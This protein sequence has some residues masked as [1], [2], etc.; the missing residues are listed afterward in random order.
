M[1]P[2]LVDTEAAD[3]EAGSGV[4][5][6]RVGVG[7]RAVSSTVRGVGVGAWM[8]GP[9]ADTLGTRGLEGVRLAVERLAVD[10][11]GPGEPAGLLTL[12]G[13]AAA[14]WALVAS[15][16]VAGGMAVAG[17]DDELLPGARVP[18]EDGVLQA[19][20]GAGGVGALEAAAARVP[21]A[22]T[23]APTSVLCVV[24]AVTAG[25]VWL[26][27]QVPLVGVMGDGVAGV[28]LSAVL[29]KTPVTVSTDEFVSECSHVWLR[30]GCS[31]VCRLSHKDQEETQTSMRA[32]HILQV[33]RERGWVVP[34]A[35]SRPRLRLLRA[36]CCLAEGREAAAQGA[37]PGWAS[38][39]ES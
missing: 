39:L 5:F 18:G 17:L 4:V 34:E 31:N 24:P 7:L 20:T 35:P 1:V 33:G 13:V 8:V 37:L 15:V 28:I 14:G 32:V 11:G 12:A 36:P 38:S 23:E 2:T 10:P 29:F 25:E 6:K 26:P 22:V 21:P 3:G 30:N 19:D 9:C 16:G 27:P